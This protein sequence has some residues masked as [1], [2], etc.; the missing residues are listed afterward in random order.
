VRPPLLEARALSKRFKVGKGAM[1][2]AVDAVDLAIAPGECVGLVGESGCGKST[3]VRLLARLIDPTSGNILLDGQDT[4]AVS[5]AKFVTM[6][7]RARIQVVFQDPSES[8]NP[9]FRV[10]ESIADPL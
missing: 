7:E 10:F 2:H 5:Q 3:L 4:T 1:L 9:S 6:P 8:L